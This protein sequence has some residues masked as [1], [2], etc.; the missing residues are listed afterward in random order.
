MALQTRPFVDRPIQQL[1]QQGMVPPLAR[2]KGP[3]A[4]NMAANAAIDYGLSKVGEQGLSK[5]MA[6]FG[7]SVG[8]PLGGALGYVGGQVAA[9]FFKRILGLKPG[10]RVPENL[11][12]FAKL[13]EKVQQ[14]MSPD[15]AKKY[16]AGNYVMPNNT[17]TM[18]DY[19][20]NS[21]KGRPPLSAEESY[22]QNMRP[23]A[24]PNKESYFQKAER[25]GKFGIGIPNMYVE[26]KKGGGSIE[27]QLEDIRPFTTIWDTMFGGNK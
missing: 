13:P 18:Q 9:P 20:L 19:Y 10:G 3:S 2:R 15:L 24:D 1:F 21:V 17:M 22:F 26:P 27:F 8:G 12:G 4:A 14:K 23:L 25:T 6:T 16:Q 5:G 7:A 11:K